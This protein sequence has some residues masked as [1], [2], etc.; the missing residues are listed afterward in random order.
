MEIAPQQK[1]VVH[2]VRAALVERLYVGGFKRRQR[3]FLGDRAGTMIGVGHLEAESALS[4]A[5]LYRRFFAVAGPFYIKALGFFI[6]VMDMVMLPGKL[7][8]FPDESPGFLI[9]FIAFGFATDNRRAPFRSRE[10]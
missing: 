8:A 10:P 9:E 5:R 1:P 6:Q 4:E 2:G 3:M 7:K